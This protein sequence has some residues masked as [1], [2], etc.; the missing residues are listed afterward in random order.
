MHRFFLLFALWGFPV[1]KAYFIS[2]RNG[3]TFLGPPLEAVVLDQNKL[4]GQPLNTLV[5]THEFPPK[6]GVLA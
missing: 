6:G 3:R 1:G 4:M 5:I 2:P